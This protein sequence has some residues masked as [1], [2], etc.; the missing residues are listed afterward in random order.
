MSGFRACQMTGLIP[1]RENSELTSGSHCPRVD[2]IPRQSREARMGRAVAVSR[3]AHSARELRATASKCPTLTRSAGYW[4]LLWCWTAPAVARPPGRAAWTARRCVTGFTATM[5]RG[6]AAFNHASARPPAE[7]DDRAESGIQGA[8]DRGADPALHGVVR[9]RCVDLQ[10][11]A[12]RRYNA[13]FTSA[14]WASGC[15]RSG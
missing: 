15:T 12:A 13:G 4:R 1:T 2:S 10:E 3:T 5:P 11:E 7:A 14:R 6:L 9:W 8:G